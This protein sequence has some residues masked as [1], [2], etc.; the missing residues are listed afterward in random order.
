MA[1][2]DPDRLAG[3]SEGKHGRSGRICVLP[4]GYETSMEEPPWGRNGEGRP[5]AW[6]CSAPDG[7]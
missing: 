4:E 6:V 1:E 3:L 7:W 5:I 2:G